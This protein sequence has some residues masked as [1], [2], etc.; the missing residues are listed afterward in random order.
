MK[1]KK[2]HLSHSVIGTILFVIV[3]GVFL[4][5]IA[6]VPLR[7]ALILLA[8]LAGGIA[9]IVVATEVI[10]EVRNARHL[11]VLLSAVVA[12]FVAFFAFQYWFLIS[13]APGSFPGLGTGG[14]DL[15]LHSTMIFVFNPIFLPA[16]AAARLLLLINTF[17]ALALVLFILQNVWQIRGK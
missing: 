3:E 9:H 10:E 7:I 11:L 13:S 5:A 1:R 8:A 14:T 15:L 17:G 4:T 12:I 16:T 6:P 2:F